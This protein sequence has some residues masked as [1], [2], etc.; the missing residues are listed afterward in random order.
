MLVREIMTPHPVTA[1]VDTSVKQ[2]LGLLAEHHITALPVLDLD[3][4]LVGVLSEG[5]LIRDLVRQDPRGHERPTAGTPAP[6][7]SVDQLMTR[8]PVCVRPATDVASAVRLLVSRGFRSLPVLDD[9][10][11]LVGMVSRSDV[12]RVVARPDDELAREVEAHVAEVGLGDWGARVDDGAV[13]LLGPA[14][15]SDRTMA[16]LVAATGRGG[17]E[18]LGGPES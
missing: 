11:R 14:G 4:A 2:A 16:Q 10:G 15:S 3:G 17:M 8:Q 6:P 12:V 13:T 1:T 18:G 9:T 5:D 7:R